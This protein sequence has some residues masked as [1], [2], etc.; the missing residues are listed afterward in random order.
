MKRINTGMLG[1]W[2]LDEGLG[3]EVKD[4]S[5]NGNDGQLRSLP[6]FSPPEWITDGPGKPGTPALRF[7]EKQFVEMK[8]ASLLEPP[9][10]TVE[11]RVRSKTP[12]P[13]GAAYILSKGANECNFASYALFTHRVSEVRGGLFFLIGTGS[14]HLSPGAE[15]SIWNGKWH[16]VAGV[17]DGRRVRLFVDG[18]PVH[19]IVDGQ[20]AGTGE[21]VDD[22]FINYNLPTNRR[23]YIGMYR[24]SCDLGFVGDISDVRVWRG[25]LLPEEIK[26]RSQFKDLP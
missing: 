13:D 17:F 2:R 25:A 10:V 15:Q 21:P 5:G 23:F 16:H 20:P 19:L 1:C 11:A 4:S 14:F 12:R 3:L 24:G 6:G 26:A 9:V 7:K 8:N 22:T 18:K